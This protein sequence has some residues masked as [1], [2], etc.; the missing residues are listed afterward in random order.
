[1][2]ILTH[3]TALQWPILLCLAILAE[4]A[5]KL[6]LGEQW[7]AAVPL[8]RIMALASLSLFP[9]FMTY[10]VLVA[11]GGVR[12]TLTMSLISIPPSIALVAIASLKGLMAVA[13]VQLLTAPLQL[14]VAMI[15]VRRYIH[16][17]W[18]EYIQALVPS[19]VVTVCAAAGAVGVL[20]TNRVLA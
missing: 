17:T 16:F 3:V 10:P 12:D 20:V 7:T 19:A 9:A 2:K 6:L 15:Y 1:M 13:I 5:V 14:C 8:V 11:S 4:P 18:S